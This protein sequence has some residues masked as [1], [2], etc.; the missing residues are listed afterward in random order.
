MLRREEILELMQKRG[1]VEYAFINKNKIQFLS[2]HMIRGQID[3][4]TINII[5]NMNDG[6]FECIYNVPLGIN[7]L[8]TPK[9]G[10]VTNDKHFEKIINKFMKSVNWLHEK[11]NYFT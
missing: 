3:K 5:V 8:I 11:F 6:S 10:S 1:Y 4:P 7:K 2:D 9:C